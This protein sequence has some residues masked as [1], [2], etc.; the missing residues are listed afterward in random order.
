[1][2][3]YQISQKIFMKDMKNVIGYSLGFIQGVESGKPAFF[4]KVG[5]AAMEML[6]G[7]IDSNARIDP[8]SLHHIYEWHRVG[9]PNARLFDIDYIITGA[10]IS[11]NG[12]LRQ[13]KTI[14]S[15]STVPFYNK[16][17]IME[18]GIPV[19][20]SPINSRV[21]RF[22]DN[23]QEVFSAGPIDVQN[24]G[25]NYVEGS[26]QRIVESFF[27]NYFTQAFLNSSGFG[28][29]L[30]KAKDF[31]TNFAKAKKGG[32]SLGIIT[33][34]TWISKAGDLSVQFITP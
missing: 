12:T 2:I 8:E 4:A 15:G 32:R 31:D 27:Q 18:Q 3:S 25:G 30:S 10:G 7:Y 19:R 20:I 16:A 9:N 14:K 33:G 22:N 21:L 23:G 24:P 28:A 13:S 34:K 6:N 17:K 11:L 5:V 26:F 1:M 29:M